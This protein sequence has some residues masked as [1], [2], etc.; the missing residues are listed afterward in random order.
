[1]AVVARSQGPSPASAS[2]WLSPADVEW[3]APVLRLIAAIGAIPQVTKISMSTRAAGVDLWVYMAE[4][5][6]EAEAAIS[7]A[8]RDFLNSG[9]PPIVEVQVIP[10]TDIDPEMLPSTTVLLE[11]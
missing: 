4:D 2:R 3:L 10:G 11:R 7:R 6:Y 1:M 5:D 8:E 9:H